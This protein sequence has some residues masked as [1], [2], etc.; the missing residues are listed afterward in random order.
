MRL[1]KFLKQARIVKRREISKEFIANGMVFVN[2]KIKKPPYE[3][4]IGDIIELHTR[5]MNS[6]FKVVNP[7]PRR[8]SEDAC[9][10]IS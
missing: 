7:E 3:V 1:D 5:K 8:S 4:K 10:R 9:E 6:K 2:G